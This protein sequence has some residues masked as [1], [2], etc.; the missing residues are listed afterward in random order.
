[1]TTKPET[2]IQA[3]ENFED[4]AEGRRV[5]LEKFMS[6][7]IFVLMDQPWDG[8]SLPSTEMRLLFVSDG[9]DKQQAMLAVFTDRAHAEAV[10]ADMGEFRHPAEV[11]ARWAMLGVPPD[12]GV[13]INPNSTP[14]FR[15]LPQLAIELRRMVEGKLQQRQGT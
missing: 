2:L 4:T 8:R 3:L 14:S 5:V 9:E 6:T 1:M 11:D 15:I 12:V 7:R 10:A 13:R